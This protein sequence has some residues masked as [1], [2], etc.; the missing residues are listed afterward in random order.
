MRLR[1]IVPL[2]IAAA[3]LTLA[4]WSGRRGRSSLAGECTV[5][6]P[7]AGTLQGFAGYTDHVTPTV[8]GF[9]TGSL[10]ITIV[11]ET[12][13]PAADVVTLILPNLRRG[14]APPAGSYQ[15]RNPGDSLTREQMVNPRL[16]W[17]RVARG[18][19]SLLFTAR[20]GTVTLLT[21]KPGALEGAYQ[22]AIAAADSALRL[23]GAQPEGGGTFRTDSA[24]RVII[25]PTVLG[26]AFVA[27][28]TEADW[29]RR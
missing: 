2:S 18:G 13:G 21:V 23:P 7:G 11:C 3:V 28:R 20:G 26:G 15:V 10:A 9:T 14:E 19:G 12:P 8:E 1:W 25:A 17:A 24:G 5:T 6:E 27:T 29:R 4:V 22:V 16:A